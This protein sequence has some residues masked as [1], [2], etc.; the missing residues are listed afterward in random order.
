MKFREVSL[1]ATCFQ[2]NMG[3]R[4]CDGDS[5]KD[6][7]MQG[8]RGQGFEA[9]AKKSSLE[10][11]GVFGGPVFHP[12]LYRQRYRAVLDVLRENNITKVN[13]V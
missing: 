7:K 11:E 2:N 9:G 6:D 12:P 5:M 3:D 8:I 4:F 13:I 1:K 10:N